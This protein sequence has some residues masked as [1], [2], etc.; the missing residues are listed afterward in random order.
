MAKRTLTVILI[1][2][3]FILAGCH[4]IDSGDSLLLS[5]GLKPRV[6][7][8]PAEAGEAD[9]VEKMSE[10]RQAYRNSLLSLV[11][12]YQQAGNNM[13]V[14]WAKDEL[15]KLDKIPQYHYIPEAVIAPPTLRATETISEADYMYKEAYRIEKKAGRLMII[16]NEDQLRDALDLYNAIIKKFPT[17]DKIDDSAYRAAGIHEYFRDYTIAVVYYKRAYQWNPKTNYIARYKAANILDLYLQRK[18]EALQLYQQSLDMDNL[19]GSQADYVK[20]RI[21]EISKGTVR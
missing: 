9:V 7:V 11:G 5:E 21:D 8:A 18:D 6:A 4:D 17:S 19:S 13:K 3:V 16:K 10:N 1:V 14:Q 12:Y 15:N 20:S 2:Y